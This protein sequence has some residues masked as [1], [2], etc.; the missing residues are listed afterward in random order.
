MMKVNKKTIIKLKAR[1]E[2]AFNIV[3]YQYIN[4]I[5]HIVY[6]IVK[7]KQDAEDITQDTFVQMMQ[8]IESFN[9]NNN[10]KYWI[11]QIAKNK[12]LDFIKKHNRIVLNEPY[13]HSIEDP[14]DTLEINDFDE[15]LKQYEHIINKEEF[16][17]ITLRIFHGLKFKEIAKIYD[18]TESTV[19][20]IYHRGIVKI[21]KEW[22]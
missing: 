13:I 20:N 1:D 11:I 10:F 12:S 16:D 22:R 4:L 7:N 8:A 19:N 9:E 14:A 21:K 17:V 6:G 15:M 5:F 18:T 3:Y 2:N